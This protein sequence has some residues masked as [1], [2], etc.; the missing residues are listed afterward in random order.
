MFVGSQW[1]RELARI[2]NHD[3]G[4]RWQTAREFDD[5]RRPLGPPDENRLPRLETE[6]PLQ[7]T[8]A[9]VGLFGCLHHAFGAPRHGLM[10]KPVTTSP[11][12]GFVACKQGDGSAGELTLPGDCERHQRIIARARRMQK[13]DQSP[14][15]GCRDRGQFNPEF[16]GHHG[17]QRTPAP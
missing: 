16:F 2:A 6:R 17:R 3:R 12:C 7:G 11:R 14:R 10:L 9:I 4:R 13:D 1:A 5:H 15:G 8:E